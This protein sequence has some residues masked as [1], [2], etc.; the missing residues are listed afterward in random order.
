MHQTVIIQ[1]IVKKAQQYY[2]KN[3]ERL[4]KKN[5]NRYISIL[6]KEQDKEREYGSN[7]LD[8]IKKY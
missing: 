2:E 4:R 3:K 7:Q 1:R 8:N 5:R 6:E